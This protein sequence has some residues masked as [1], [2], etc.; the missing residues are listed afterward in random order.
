MDTWYAVQ[1]KRY[2][3]RRTERYLGLKSIPTLVPFIEVVRRC[4]GRKVRHLEALFPGYLFARMQPPALLPGPWSALRW[5]P[6]VRRILGTDDA[7]VAVPEEV[8]ETIKARMSGLGY[9]KPEIRYLPGSSVRIRHGPLAGF[10]AIFECPL[11]RAERVRVLLQLL[12]QT[13]AVELDLV[14]LEPS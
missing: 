13:R 4:S 5:A 6:G 8:I 2:E 14:D 12:G 3:E 7:P 11:S 10:D 9:V 1:V